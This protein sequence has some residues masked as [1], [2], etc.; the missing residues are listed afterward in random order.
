MPNAA[1]LSRAVETAT[2]CWA[3]AALRDSSSSAVPRVSQSHSRARRALVRVSRVPNVL[4]ATMNSVGRRV[5]ALDL[6][7]QVRRVDVGDEPHLEAV[8]HVRLERLVGHDGPEVGAADADVHDGRDPLAGHAGPRAGPHL[9][10]ERVHLGELGLYV[11]VDLLSVHDERR[12]APGGRRRAVCRTARSSVTLMWSPRSWA[13][14]RSARPTSSASRSS[15]ATVS[16]VTR[17]FDR[18]TVRSASGNVRRARARGRRR[19]RR[20]GPVTASTRAR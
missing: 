12:V 15:S 5:E 1:T 2:K 14:R 9:L 11:G 10:R 19:T 6:L 20:A 18:S 4:D 3:T 13:A 17:F 16:S 7:G 8:L